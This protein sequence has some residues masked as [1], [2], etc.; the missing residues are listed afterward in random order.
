MQ[1]G[2]PY[3]AWGLSHHLTSLNP[4]HSSSRFPQPTPLT[5]PPDLMPLTT[6]LH[7]SSQP[8]TGN[9]TCENKWSK[10][11]LTG[12]PGIPRGPSF[13]VSPG[14]PLGP[15]G[16]G[17][18]GGPACPWSPCDGERNRPAITMKDKDSGLLFSTL[19]LHYLIHIYTMKRTRTTTNIKPVGNL[20]PSREQINIHA[21]WLSRCY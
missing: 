3:A 9:K 4:L 12:T 15:G 21:G 16:P 18:P 14:G 20:P 6:L 11:W 5:W 10:K 17:G 2:V 13:P 8:L 1:L 19:N 7:P